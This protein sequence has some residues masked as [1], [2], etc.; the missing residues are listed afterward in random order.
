MKNSK[1]RNVDFLNTTD[2]KLKDV[3][4][5]IKKYAGETYS[6][7]NS[8]GYNCPDL[9]IKPK[10]WEKITAI[11]TKGFHKDTLNIN[12]TMNEVA[13]YCNDNKI[14]LNFAMV[15]KLFIFAR[16]VNVIETIMAVSNLK[17]MPELDIEDQ[18]DVWMKTMDQG[19]ETLVERS[20]QDEAELKSDFDEAINDSESDP[21]KL[22]TVISAFEDDIED[23]SDSDLLSLH[24]RLKATLSMS[25]AIPDDYKSDALKHLD[26]LG[27]MMIGKVELELNTRSSNN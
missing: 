3:E 18:C 1:G 27:R 15:Y 14:P 5:V 2:Q 7:S 11:V 16:M 9:G 19:L 25:T 8:K 12:A 6:L 21:E 10:A 23:M 13:D 24:Y 20:K 17:L 26:K 4:N 22:I